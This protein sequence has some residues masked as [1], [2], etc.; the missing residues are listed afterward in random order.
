MGELPERR[1]ELFAN[2]I[3]RIL[4]EEHRRAAVASLARERRHYP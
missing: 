4:L 1:G 3:H 2:P